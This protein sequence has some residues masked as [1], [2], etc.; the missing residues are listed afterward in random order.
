MFHTWVYQLCEEAL[1]QVETVQGEEGDDGGAGT[2]VRADGGH[3]D[4]VTQE[5]LTTLGGCGCE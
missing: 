1:L 3:G 5:Q 2:Q 4:P